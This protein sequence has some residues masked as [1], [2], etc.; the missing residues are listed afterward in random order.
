MKDVNGA[1]PVAMANKTVQRL[2]IQ[3]EIP[4]YK[5]G[6][7]PKGLSL[8]ES[9]AAAVPKNHSLGRLTHSGITSQSSGGRTSKIGVPEW[10]GSGESQTAGFP[11]HPH[12]A[13]RQPDS[14]LASSTRARIP[15]RGSTSMTSPPPNT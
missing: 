11:L 7:Q 9:A 13:E 10:W 12:G 8:L 14:S 5:E 4:G 1:K 6:L 15:P 3:D 2:K